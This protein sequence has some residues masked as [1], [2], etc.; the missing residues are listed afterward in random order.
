MSRRARVGVA[1]FIAVCALALA[2]GRAASNLGRTLTAMAEARARQMAADELNSALKYVLDASLTYADFMQ[3]TCDA[4]GRV[5]MLSTNTMLMD[6]LAAGAVECAQARLAALS[7]QG[8]TLPAGA[9]LGINAL[10][11]AGPRIR[12]SL[13]PVG[14]VTAD[15]VT[16]FTDAG[17]N[18]TRHTI[19]L[20]AAASVQ[21]VI[22]TGAQLISVRARIPIAESILVG[23]VPQSYIQVPSA[24]DALNFAP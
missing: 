5:N 17:I 16:E 10:S 24:G 15:F 22:P 12:F 23:E 4:Q 6:A 14:V 1:A 2:A 20:E 21:I 3:V 9:A 7:E 18:Q 19:F 13:V 11:G 8:V